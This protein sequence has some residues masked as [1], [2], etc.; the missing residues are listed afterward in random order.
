M[1]DLGN[2]VKG[3]SDD[4][5]KEFRRFVNELK[6]DL[7][8]D[9]INKIG[10]EYEVDDIVVLSMFPLICNTTLIF[11]LFKKIIKNSYCGDSTQIE[12]IIDELKVKSINNTD[13]KG[14]KW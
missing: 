9:T 5:K 14:L 11:D 10:T 3:M 12:E 8:Q 7:V 1:M 2:E 4:S 6:D 13:E